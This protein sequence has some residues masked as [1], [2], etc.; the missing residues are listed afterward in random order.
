MSWQVATSAWRAEPDS[1]RLP[2]AVL[3]LCFLKHLPPV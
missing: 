3:R 1:N 2:F